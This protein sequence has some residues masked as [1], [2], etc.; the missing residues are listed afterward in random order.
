MVV[1]GT[2]GLVGNSQGG[3]DGRPQVGC[4]RAAWGVSFGRVDIIT[5]VMRLMRLMRR[6]G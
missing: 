6:D 3:L 2:L 5:D 1:F 4:P